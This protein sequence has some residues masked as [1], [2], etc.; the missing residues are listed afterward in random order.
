VERTSALAPEL[1]PELETAGREALVALRSFGTA[2]RDRIAT[3]DEPGAFAVGEEQFERRLRYEHALLAGAGELWR[4]GLRL[5]E[6]VEADLAALAREI[7]PQ[8]SWRE[9]VRLL[10]EEGTPDEGEVLAQYRDEVARAHAFLVERS[11][12]SLTEV[13]LEVVATPTYLRPML[14]FAAYDMPP[15]L[16]PGRPGHFYVTEPE[17][18]AS[19]QERMAQL[20]EHASFGLP[21]LVAHEAWPGHHLQLTRAQAL[22]SEVRRHLWSPLT[23]EGW[24]LYCEGLMDELGF[25]PSQEVRLF[26][27][28]DL[29]W[30][31]V[32]IDIDIGLH[33]RGMS[34]SEAVEE[35]VHRLPMERSDAIA[36]VRRYC[37]MPT[38]QL[39][40]AVGRRDL[41]ALREAA[42]AARGPAFSLRGFHD[43]VLSYGG[44]PVSLIR[45][46]MEA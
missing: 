21:S 5:R 38:Y 8:R 23:V 34:V 35:L 25:Y 42:Q 26:R 18:G 32:R 33:T 20:R 30:R 12:V 1:A 29:L 2:L 43:E 40:Y 27:M 15:I 16:L 22:D 9:L 4:Y 45:W 10:R 44:L 14:P 31:A 6:E 11:V 17:P 13:P 24:A 36:E 28:V 46:G 19:D 41:L 39:C 37:Q 3:A 7:D